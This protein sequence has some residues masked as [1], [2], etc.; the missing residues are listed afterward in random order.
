LSLSGLL[1]SILRRQLLGVLT[2][3]L[4][5]LPFC[6]LARVLFVVLV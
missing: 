3:L 2:H 1:P 4:F 6:L 5:N